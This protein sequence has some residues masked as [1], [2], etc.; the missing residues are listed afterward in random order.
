MAA[1]AHGRI[2]EQPLD[3]QAQ[4]R[5]P[6]VGMARAGVVGDLGYNCIMVQFRGCAPHV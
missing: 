2:V 1:L 4:I 3:L 6:V 5:E